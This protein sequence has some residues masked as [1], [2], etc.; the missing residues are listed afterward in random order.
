MDLGL[1]GKVALTTAS[2]KGL[3]RAVANEFAREGAKV[4]IC[5]RDEFRLRQTAHDISTATG[6]PVVPIVADVTRAQDI[7][8]LVRETLRRFGR[9]DI[10]VTNA[11]GPPPGGFEDH[12]DAAW[13]AAW[14]LTLMSC[15]RLIREVLPGMKAQ[16]WGRIINLT[17]TSARQP[18][19]NLVFSN[20]YRAAVVGL[21]KSLS[22]EVAPY[23]ITVNNVAAGTIATDRMKQ[24]A[25]KRAE[26][27]SIDLQ[28]SLA[29]YAK[30]ADLGRLG[31]PEEFA[32]AVVFLASERA[33][34]ITGVT[35]PV[36]GG[37]IRATW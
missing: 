10:L 25:E 36:D 4:V 15:V 27:E 30:E 31:Q 6:N 34:F 17:G 20:V 8:N 5:A 23:N 16:R 12:D 13:E 9:I 37:M 33:S 26:A 3:G 32:A 24:L 11:G 22:H 7:L 1:A 29:R 21:G 35:L 2:S 14:R 18:M 28:E 19:D